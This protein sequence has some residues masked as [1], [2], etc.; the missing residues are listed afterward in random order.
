MDTSKKPLVIGVVAVT[1]IIAVIAV[2]VL[3]KGDS[4]RSENTAAENTSSTTGED[5][6]EQKQKNHEYI[7]KLKKDPNYN[8]PGALIG[9]AQRTWPDKSGKIDDS[10]HK[11]P[12]QYS[13]DMFQQRPVWTPINHDGDLPKKSGLKDGFE[14]CKNPDKITLEGKTQQQ[15]VN[16]RYLVVNE[17]SGPTKMERGVPRGYAHSPQGAILA[18][19]NMTYYG[20]P[21]EDEIG[22][23]LTK[24]LWNSSVKAQEDLFEDEAFMANYRPEILPSPNGFKVTQC[25]ENI[26]VVET[27]CYAQDMQLVTR[28]PMVWKGGDWQAD[29]SGAADNQAYQESESSKLEKEGKKDFAEISYS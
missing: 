23:E 5:S 2:Y 4:P 1:I 12:G 27:I 11:T 22:V 18:T 16:A 21:Q 29:L 20:R 9:N 24:T 10:G 3:T 14:G 17:Q 6:V 13:P 8:F 19:I 26:I 28:I 15:Y 7:E 25:S